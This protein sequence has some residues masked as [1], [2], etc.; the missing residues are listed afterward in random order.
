LEPLT[1]WLDGKVTVRHGYRRILSRPAIASVTV[2]L[3]A[4]AWWAPIPPVQ[5]LWFLSDNPRAHSHAQAAASQRIQTGLAVSEAITRL[6]SAD[7]FWR[8]ADCGIAPSSSSGFASDHV[9]FYGSHNHVQ[10]GIVVVRARGPSPDQQVVSE[11]F[12]PD[13]DDLERVA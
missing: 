9:F 3:A 10:V 8:Q 6:R 11:I 13:G 7:G 4:M 1:D 2:L 12:R 5:D